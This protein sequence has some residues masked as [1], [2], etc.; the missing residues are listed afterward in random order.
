MAQSYTRQSTFADGDTITAALFNNEYDQLVNAFSYSSTNSTVTGHTHD[1]SSGQGGNIGKIGDIDF[2]NKIEVD[3][4]N[5]RWGVYVEV[6][7]VS[8]EQVRVQDGSIVPVTTNDIDL[9]SGSLQFKDLFIDG[10]AS[11][12]SLTLSS[13]V[14]VDVIL[15]EDN[16]VS[17]SATALATQQS[18][19]AYVDS[20][21]TAQDLDF[22]ADTGGAL[23]IDLDSETLVLAGGTGIDT[24][25]ALNTVTIAIDATVATL[26]DAQTLTNKTIDAASN[27]LSNIANASLTNST[28]SYGGV[29]LS[30]GGSDAT[31]A[32]NLVDATGYLG[33]S[34]LV[35]TGALN[36]GSI[37]SGFGS[38]D[39]GS[40]SITTLGTVSGGTLTGTL[41][42]AAQ[43]NVTSVGT[44][45]S[46]AVSGDLTVDTSTLK[47]DSA[48]NRVGI[49]NAAPDVTLDI[50][51]ATD[52]VHVPVGTTAQRPGTPAAGYFRY[53]ADLEQFEGYTDTWGAI[54]GGGTNTFTFDSFTGDNTTVDFVLS[55]ATNL[56][57]NLIVFIDGVFQTQDAYTIATA[58]GITTLTFSAAPATGR[59]IAVY[60][61]SAGVSG[62]NMNLDSFSGDELLQT[63]RCLSMLLTKTTLR[64]LLMVFI[65]KKMAIP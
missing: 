14:T 31:P 55:Q 16:L 44:L 65:S 40:S 8:T 52:A 17:D 50:G 59:Y 35:T 56:E 47:V 10:T 11:I 61:V 64:S 38:I 45:T 29:Q 13:G 2:L 21:V 41:S 32:F 34:A 20:Q 30:L 36:S 18:I 43:A 28:V 63:L 15:D 26:A 53:N 37:T 51:S 39:V 42:T 49:L 5:N 48:N 60:T 33:D 57:G 1:G 19:K 27:T 25:G 62:N 12:D 9:G 46:L 22:Q 54:G 23:N 3:N 24:S 7:G 58:S 6:T 4:V